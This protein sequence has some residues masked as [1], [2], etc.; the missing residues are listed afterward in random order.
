MALQL[1]C[2][3][4]NH[5][6]LDLVGPVPVQLHAYLDTAVAVSS[7]SHPSRS[8]QVPQI[9]ICCRPSMIPVEVQGP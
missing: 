5:P 3:I 2:E 8:G 6:E 4:V 9:A 7:R 1:I